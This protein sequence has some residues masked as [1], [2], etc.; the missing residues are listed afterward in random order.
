V[1]CGGSCSGCDRGEMCG[2]AGDC[3]TDGCVGGRCRVGPTASFTLAPASGRAPLLVSA[4]STATFGDAA[5]TS[6]QY[7]F[8]SGYAAATS[9][10]F[11]SPGT[12][13]VRQRVTDANGLSATA[14]RSVEVTDPFVFDCRLSATD[15][16]ASPILELSPDRLAIEW[17]LL[18]NGGVRSECAVMPGSGV[19]YF[20]ASVEPYECDRADVPLGCVPTPRDQL[21][22][23]VATSSAD[24]TVNPGATASGFDVATAGQFYG[25]GAY[26]GSYPRDINTTW[27]F[28]LDYRSASN[29][30]VYAIANDWG[31]V[32][33][34]Q[35]FT[36]T[37]AAPIYAMAS[38]TRRK[39]GP[40]ISFNF[41]NDTTNVPFEYDVD[42]VLR[43]NGF[44]AVADA[45]TLGWTGTNA[46]PANARPTLSVSGDLSV[47]LGTSVNLTG[48]ATDA[49]DGTLTSSIYWED[50]ATVYN[51][52]D[53]AIGGSFAFTPRVVGLHP[54][55]ATVVDSAGL[56]RQRIVEVNV[57]GPIPT[58]SPVVLVNDPMVDPLVGSGVDVSADGLS[59]RWTVYDKMGLR[60]N[61][62]IF[63]DF[64][65]FEFS[66]L[67]TPINQGGG[68]VIGEGDLNPYHAEV[69]PPSV[70]INTLT[71]TW[72]NIIFIGGYD[73]SASTYGFAVDYR[74]T[75]PIV[76]YI[77]GGEVVNE[78]LMY[79]A[80]VPIYPMLY[81]N[82]TEQGLP[83]DSRANFGATPFV[84]D[85]C[86]ALQAY[87][88]SAADRAAL[89]VGWGVHA[90]GLCP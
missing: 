14:M 41:G 43:A 31:G 23:G 83:Y 42:A 30:V 80:F 55:R 3:N 19:Y 73:N 46:R 71:G 53:E 49:E 62:P 11:S 79:D 86:A 33:V 2:V 61:A 20:E 75:N 74:G 5:I 25:G 89:R 22:V 27:G 85:P 29:P 72:Q 24:L 40:E 36:L 47:A 15:R 12:Y 35:T 60:A 81:G 90:T 21:S 6:T 57:T 18:N 4:T 44:G 77:V 78:W 39:V 56:R 38:G 87:G 32:D 65:Y 69:V 34:M 26:L 8:G 52:R 17:N 16:T 37:T 70:S 88:V 50:L 64:W 51:D 58:P 7:D 63:G 76:Y 67:G 84:Q 45:L 68:L 59:A 9:R 1:D 66:R 13:V 28:V 54:V 82:P 10:T 48:T